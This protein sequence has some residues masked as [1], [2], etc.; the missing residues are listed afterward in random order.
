MLLVRHAGHDSGWGTLGEGTQN[1]GGLGATSLDDWKAPRSKIP[2]GTAGAGTCMTLAG[3]C[4]LRPW[5][6]GWSYAGTGAGAGRVILGRSGAGRGSSP[7]AFGVHW[8]VM[9]AEASGRNGASS[10]PVAWQARRRADRTAASSVRSPA[11]ARSHGRVW[12]T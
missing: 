2:S 3:S 4:V 11:L 7:A 1:L 12:L 9:R 10:V 8:R 5:R 6:T